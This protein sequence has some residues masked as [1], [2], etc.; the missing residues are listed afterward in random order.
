MVKIIKNFSASLA[1]CIRFYAHSKIKVK[2]KSFNS[3]KLTNSKIN[4]KVRHQSVWITFSF[5]LKININHTSL[6]IKKII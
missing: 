3:I 6:Q 1:D 2:W 4:L 5:N